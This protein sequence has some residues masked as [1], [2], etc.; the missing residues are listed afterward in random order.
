[1][2]TNYILI[3]YESMCFLMTAIYIMTLIVYS[4]YDG[5]INVHENNSQ[6][7]GGVQ[8]CLKECLTPKAVIKWSYA[9]KHRLGPVIT[10]IQIYKWK[11][12]PAHTSFMF[13]KGRD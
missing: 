7:E 5:V 12:N 13:T 8:T 1:M 11:E 4:K 6:S 9:V 3:T 2:D 10:A